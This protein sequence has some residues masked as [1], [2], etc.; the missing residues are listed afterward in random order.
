[1][2]LDFQ[3]TLCYYCTLFFGCT[4]DFFP[5]VETGHKAVAGSLYI[6]ILEEL[7]VEL[8]A[9][10]ICLQWLPRRSALELIVESMLV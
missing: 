1:V 3:S 4:T 5:A 9:L 8:S 10:Y 7:F 6:F 2:G